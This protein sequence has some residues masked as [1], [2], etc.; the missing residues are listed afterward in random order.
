MRLLAMG[1]TMVEKDIPGVM[2]RASLFF[3]M[4]IVMPVNAFSAVSCCNDSR[5]EIHREAAPCH[6]N[7]KPEA[8]QEQLCSWDCTLCITGLFLPPAKAEH[9]LYMKY[10]Q[11]QASMSLFYSNDLK[12]PFKPPKVS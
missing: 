10:G 6:E 7:S 8:Q 3:L 11:I 12:P 9:S 1:F 2:V 5:H 4:I